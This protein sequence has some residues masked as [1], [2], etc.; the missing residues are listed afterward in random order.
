M[1]P[2]KTDKPH[3]SKAKRGL[4]IL[5][6]FAAII[7]ANCVAGQRLCNYIHRG[8]VRAIRERW[9]ELRNAVAE[10]RKDKA[11]AMVLPEAGTTKLEDWQFDG[12]FTGYLVKPETPLDGLIVR[13]DVSWMGRRATLYIG[14]GLLDYG[15]RY[16]LRRNQADGLWYFTGDE[17]VY[18][19]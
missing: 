8:E 7:F 16:H 12:L 6:A 19:D 1:E 13:I 3:R 10:G 14:K 9:A 5:L 4:C 17:D 11:R 18:L 15:E 2:V